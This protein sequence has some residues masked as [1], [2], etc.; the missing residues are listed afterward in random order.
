[1]RRNDRVTVPHI[2]LSNLDDGEWLGEVTR[3]IDDRSPYGV[4]SRK[5]C[6]AVVL[7]QL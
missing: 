2:L 7:G 5:L 3:Q 6:E 1:M 4:V